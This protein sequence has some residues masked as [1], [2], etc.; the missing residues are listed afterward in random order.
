MIPFW[1]IMAWREL[2]S[3]RRQKVQRSLVVGYA[4]A[5][6]PFV[7]SELQAVAERVPRP[8]IL[9]SERAT[10]AA[11]MAEVKSFDLVHIACHGQFREDNPMYSSVRLADGWVTAND[12]L[13]Q[14]L[15]AGLVTLSA[16]ETGMSKVAGS[17]EIMGLARGFVSAGAGSLV[18]SLWTVNDEA[19]GVI[20]SKFYDHLR[21]KT[22]G[23]ALRAAQREMIAVDLH[24]YFWAPFIKIGK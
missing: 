8:T 2:R 19:T 13:K 4:D 12:I 17:E 10:F 14:R 5:A 15:K 11:F 22:P 9:N 1:L 16:C 20:M 6:I 18:L 7:E 21:S 24:P 23:A 3:R